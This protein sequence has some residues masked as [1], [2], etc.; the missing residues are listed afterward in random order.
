MQQKFSS[1][2]FGTPHDGSR[3]A[4]SCRDSAGDAED[5]DGT[6]KKGGVLGSS[7]PR[8]GDQAA[9]YKGEVS[10]MS[11]RLAPRVSPPVP[12][13]L[14]LGT[15]PRRDPVDGR[16]E[17]VMRTQIPGHVSEVDD[18]RR[19]QPSQLCRTRMER[20]VEAPLDWTRTA[21][22]LGGCIPGQPGS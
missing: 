22:H 7:K 15:R 17:L 6:F 5:E 20:Q 21:P 12:N 3:Q 1:P 16:R 10:S 8:E 13:W 19:R 4:E 2:R 9:R 11:A 14:G 18:G